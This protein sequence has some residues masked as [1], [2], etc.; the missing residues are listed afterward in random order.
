MGVMDSVADFN[1]GNIASLNIFEEIG[2]LRGHFTTIGCKDENEER[3]NNS[4]RRLSYSQKIHTWHE[5]I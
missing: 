4:V 3:C 5:K 1:D 2:M